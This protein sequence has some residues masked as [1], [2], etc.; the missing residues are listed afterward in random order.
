MVKALVATGVNQPLTVQD[1]Q[2]RRLADGDVRVRITAAG[3]CHSDLSLL[4]GTL[5]PQFPII[6]GHEAAGRVVEIGSSVTDV[7]IGDHVVLNWATPCRECWFCLQGEPWLCS[8]VEGAVAVDT[9]T[10]NAAGTVYSA[11]GVGAFAE[12]VVVP[13]ASVIPVPKALPWE[14]AA[15]LG[16][17]VLTGVGAVQNTGH[18]EPGQTAL[19]IGLGGIGLSAVLGAR[20]S[21]AS[22]IIAA[23]L[24][25]DKEALA[26]SVGAT[27]F[28][29]SDPALARTVRQLTDGRG[30][31]QAFECVGHPATIR[32]AWTSVR[33]GGSCTIVGVGSKTQEVTF[34]PLE[35]FHFSRTLTSSIYGASDPDKD[36]PKLVDHYLGGR[37][38]LDA[39]ITH[40][41]GLNDVPTA[42]ERMATGSGVRTVAV[43]EEA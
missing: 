33:R 32:T 41:V 24:N 26:R 14:V 1:V 20:L 22:K 31:D 39:L 35:L 3:V 30:V 12:E 7:S 17:A 40:R 9:G 37:L 38:N 8:A 21:G 42:F 4:N 15:L 5:A 18:V 6:V 2:L 43:F 19:V 16:C 34:N 28:V 29:L 10:T 36:I 23:D 25:P 27:D 13:S 11:L